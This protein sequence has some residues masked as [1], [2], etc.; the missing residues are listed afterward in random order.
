MAASALTSLRALRSF[1]AVA[2]LGSFRKAAEFLSISQ[3]ALSGQ[4]RD[5]E[6]D[7][8]AVLLRRTTRQVQLTESGRS[9]LAR[10]RRTITDLDAAV[11]DVRTQAKVDSG[12]VSVACV[13]SIAAGVYPAIIRAFSAT[14]PEVVIEL[15]DHRTE[16]TESKVRQSEVDFGIAPGPG[17]P[18]LNFDPIID[19]HYFA[20][21]PQSHA[22]ANAGSI[23]LC[24]LLKQPLIAMRPEQSM[25][26]S[27]DH[28]AKAVGLA[29][30]PTYEVYHH[31]TLIGMVA[32]GLGVAAVPS[33]TISVSRLN[34][35]AIV[36]IS[37]P[38]VSRKIGLLTR[39][40]EPLTGPA[41]ALAE[42]TRSYLLAGGKIEG[43][44]SEKLRKRQAD[45]NSGAQPMDCF[46]T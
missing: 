8:G 5:L 35:I 10:I 24:E 28:A 41:R 3:P 37:N 14:H 6:S 1:I 33:L 15:S 21:F 44:E 34:N 16:I 30:H 17:D 46:G 45:A 36:P 7:L 23:E 22:L 13:P 4:I 18:E 25:R 19:D 9:F 12:H 32:E 20:I 2:E 39:R 43:P 40:G 11:F 42:V 31:D 38:G 27:L 29:V 26:R